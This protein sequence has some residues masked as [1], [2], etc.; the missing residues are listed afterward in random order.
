MEIYSKIIEKVINR[1]LTVLGAVCLCILSTTLLLQI[2]FRYFLRSALTWSD[3]LSKYM[4]VWMVFLVF[5]LA[6]QKG[7]LLGIEIVISRVPRK[8]E[9]VFKA[10]TYV[11]IAMLLVILIKEG[12]EL[13]QITNRQNSPTLPFK[14]SFVYA[15]V[16]VGS[17]FAL[18]NLIDVC[19]KDLF[20]RKEA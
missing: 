10:L 2:I 16:P 5:G 9:R 14:M 6:I 19:Y 20:R 8:V 17:S 7:T 12:I 1:G 4:M 13:V 3:E 15:S 18:L 11:F